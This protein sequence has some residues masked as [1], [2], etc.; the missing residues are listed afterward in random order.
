[1]FW[2]YPR[3]ITAH[4][5]VASRKYTWEA[6]EQIEMIR[7]KR[8]CFLLSDNPFET[9]RE[10]EFSQT[11]GFGKENTRAIV[12]I[13]RD[14]LAP[15]IDRKTVLTPEQKVLVFLDYIRSNSLQRVLGKQRHAGLVLFL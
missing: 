6:Y 5:F 2:F 12:E 9:Y 3:N 14:S 4:Y 7:P 11:F 8:F 10:D 15:K 1:M 13:V